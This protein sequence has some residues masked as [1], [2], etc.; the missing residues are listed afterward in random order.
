M[1]KIFA[2]ALA[3]VMVLSM[4]SAF[5][6]PCATGPYNW[7]TTSVSACGKA[8]VEVV[9]YVKAP[10]ACG[11]YTWQ[12]S[13]CAAVVAS[14]HVYYAVKLT[15]D[16][17]PDLEWVQKASV[18]LSSKGLE[19]ALTATI[20]LAGQTGGVWSYGIDEDADKQKVYY[21]SLNNGNYAWNEI[22]D[23]FTVA[24]NVEAIGT[25]TAP[26]NF[27]MNGV[28]GGKTVKVCAKLTSASGKFTY[29]V[30]GDYVVEVVYDATSGEVTEVKVFDKKDTKLAIYDVDDSTHKVKS[31]VYTDAVSDCAP[32]SQAAIEAFFGLST[33]SKVNAANVKANFAWDDKVEDCFTWNQ[34]TSIVDAEC[35]VA[36]PKTGDA[37]VLAWLF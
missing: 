26:N 9:P 12:V 7:T 4:A 2:I 28:A 32:Y 15:V 16:A 37:S 23:T 10:D 29:G 1:K 34:V 20:P 5:A 17:N 6:S 35:V 19:T 33:A 8:T 27:I 36:I 13:E 14:E 31:V 18:A 24:D 3:L 25:A 11:G 22:T 21:L 30:V